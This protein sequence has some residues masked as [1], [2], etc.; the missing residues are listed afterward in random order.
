[1]ER[2]SEK[3]PMMEARLLDWLSEDNL[4]RGYGKTREQI[5]EMFDNELQ[6]I[7]YIPTEYI[8]FVAPNIEDRTI[9]CGKAYFIDHALR[10]HAKSNKQTSVDAIDVRQYLLIQTVLDNPDSIKETFVDGKRTIVF[11]KKIGRYYAELTQVE[12][13]GK[14]VLHKSY[15]NQKKEPY[16]KLV[17]IRSCV[18]LPEGGTSSISRVDKATPAISLESRGNVK[19]SGDK[20]NASV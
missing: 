6:P 9:Y 2:L 10:N 8:D 14:I 18:T 11:I 3:R 4:K 1:M 12:E 15:F 7:A 19:T 16:A 5:F 20:D 13:G 17:D